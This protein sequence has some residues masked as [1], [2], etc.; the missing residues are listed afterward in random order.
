MLSQLNLMGLSRAKLV[1]KLLSWKPG[2]PYAHY[3]KFC[4]KVTVLKVIRIA[5]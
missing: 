2:T 5:D 3:K 1:S 4:P